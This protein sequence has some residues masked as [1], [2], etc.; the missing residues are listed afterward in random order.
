MVPCLDTNN[1][2]AE[3]I[4]LA[5]RYQGSKIDKAF[6]FRQLFIQG[7]ALLRSCTD[8]AETILQCGDVRENTPNLFLVRMPTRVALAR[9]QFL[10]LKR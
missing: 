1:S 5:W 8:I 9:R 3:I 10:Q 7:K 6:E 4:S 2:G